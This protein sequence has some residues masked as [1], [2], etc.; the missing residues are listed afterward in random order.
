[1]KLSDREIIVKIIKIITQPGE[2]IT[3][4]ECLDEVWGW[5]KVNG[6]DTDTYKEND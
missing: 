5:L 4:G 2:N 3:D 6:Y 1:M